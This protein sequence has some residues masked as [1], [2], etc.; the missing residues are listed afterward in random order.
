MSS[1]LDYDKIWGVAGSSTMVPAPV[2][3]KAWE[4]C[5]VSAPAIPLPPA[6]WSCDNFGL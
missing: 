5:G 4:A 6:V 2:M 1:A 3:Q